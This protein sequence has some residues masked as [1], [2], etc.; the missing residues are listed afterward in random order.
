VAMHFPRDAAATT[1][2]RMTDMPRGDNGV[3]GPLDLEPVYPV[4]PDDDPRQPQSFPK[5]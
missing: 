3:A 1:I 4:S 2:V 5:I